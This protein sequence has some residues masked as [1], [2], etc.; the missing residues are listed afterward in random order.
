MLILPQ[1]N[2]ENPLIDEVETY[3]KNFAKVFSKPQ[4]VHF[5][6]IIKGILFTK[7]KSTNSYSKSSK[8]HQTSL[9]RFMNSKA[10]RQDEIQ[11]FLHKEIL[12]KI[13]KSKEVDFIFDDTIKHHKYAEHIYGLGT[14]HDH[15]Q[16]GYS[17]GHSLVTGGI[18][19]GDYFYPTNCELYQRKE[20][21]RDLSSFKTKIEIDQ[22]MLDQFLDKVDNVLMD[23]WYSKAEILSRISKEGKTFFTML[24]KNRNVKFN[25]KIKRQ[26]QEQKKYIHNRE[27]KQIFVNNQHHLVC[28]KIAILPDVG[29]VKILFTKFY[30]PITKIAK[31]VHYLCTN[32]LN[33]SAKEIL[34]KYKDRWPIETFHRDIKQNFGFEKCIIRNQIGIK[35]HFLMQFIAHNILVFSKRKPISYGKTQ[36]ELKYSYI[37]NVLQNYGIKDH[38]LEACKKELMILC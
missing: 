18:K 19:Q 37:E 15:L 29:K 22:E 17:K 32:N 7:L 20:E 25:R 2:T 3:I 27:Y 38:N 1:M 14:H 12:S 6:Q 35:R 8:K 16:N 24:K 10:V 28:E 33:L 36:L 13:D 21:I 5:E 31:E 9:S 30:N 23:S 34:L 11:K 26:L 4:L